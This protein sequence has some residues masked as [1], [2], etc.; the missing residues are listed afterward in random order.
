MI[1]D[2]NK[3]IC[4]QQQNLLSDKTQKFCYNKNSKPISLSHNS[5]VLDDASRDTELHTVACNFVKQPGT[6]YHLYQRDSGQR[7]FSVLSPE[8]GLCV[9]ILGLLCFFFVGFCV[10]ILRRKKIRTQ[11]RGEVFSP[12]IVLSIS[13]FNSARFVLLI[14]FLKLVYFN[15]EILFFPFE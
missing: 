9:V 12:V 15:F 11:S 4:L 10:L 2:E 5:Q 13:S 3:L 1:H 6:I 14:F 8:V 7:Y